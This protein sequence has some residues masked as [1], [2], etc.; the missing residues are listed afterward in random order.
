MTEIC[1]TPVIAKLSLPLPAVFGPE[2]AFALRYSLHRTV[3]TARSVS[4]ANA[5]SELKCKTLSGGIYV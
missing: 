5:N 1:T 3:G 4:Q 2:L